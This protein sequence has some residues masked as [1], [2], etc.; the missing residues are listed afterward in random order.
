MAAERE[1][2]ESNLDETASPPASSSIFSFNPEERRP[3]LLESFASVV[4]IWLM[5]SRAAEKECMF[6]LS[7]SPLENHSTELNFGQEYSSK[8]LH[9]EPSLIID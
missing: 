9:R 5:D 3:K 8:F 1:M 7:F 4:S 6:M 2:V